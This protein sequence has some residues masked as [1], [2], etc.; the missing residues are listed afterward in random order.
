MIEKQLKL[1]GVTVTGGRDGWNESDLH[2]CIKSKFFLLSCPT[3]SDIVQPLAEIV[4]IW[5]EVGHLL[6]VLFRNQVQDLSHMP[7]LDDGHALDRA[8]ALHPHAVDIVAAA[9][10]AQFAQ[11]VEIGQCG[12]GALLPFN[13]PTEKGDTLQVDVSQGRAQTRSKIQSKSLDIKSEGRW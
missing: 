10:A 8:L 7:I 3:C 1:A 11:A 2:T 5:V 6:H 12:H 9:G 13:R 4:V